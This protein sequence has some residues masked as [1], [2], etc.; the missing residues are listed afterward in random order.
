[1]SKNKNQQ[2]LFGEKNWMF[3]IVFLLVIVFIFTRQFFSSFKEVLSDPFYFLVVFSVGVAVAA[4]IIWIIGEG[5]RVF[6][7]KDNSTV[8][9]DLFFVLRSLPN[10][11][12]SYQNLKLDEVSFSTV[13][14]G[15]KTVSVIETVDDGSSKIKKKSGGLSTDVNERKI[16][17]MRDYLGDS[18]QINFI[19]VYEKNKKI[20]RY[21]DPDVTEPKDLKSV[22]VKND[23]E[24]NVLVLS[25]VEEKLEK[26]WKKDLL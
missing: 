14:V 15:L 23:L 7:N 5:K 16:R 24:S 25:E 18:V 13:V 19:L 17:K 1:M 3:G 22:L 11:F 10:D 26:L 2:M 20:K 6:F 8:E 4:P 21:L 9:S 12:Y